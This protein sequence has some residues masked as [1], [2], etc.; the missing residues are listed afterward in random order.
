MNSTHHGGYGPSIQQVRRKSSACWGEV[1]FCL[2]TRLHWIAKYRTS[3]ERVDRYRQPLTTRHSHQDVLDDRE[4]EL[5]VEACGDLSAPRGF[6][7]RFICLLGG[8]PGPRAG[9]SAQFHT[10][11]LDWNRKVLRIPQHEP[12]NRGYCKRQARQEVAHNDRLIEADAVSSRWHPK[13]VASA[14]SIPFDLSIAR[15]YIRISGTATADALRRAHHREQNDHP[16]VRPASA[17]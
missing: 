5:Q 4:F 15:K 12:C 16:S 11:R 3:N 9:E 13:T 1:A 7:A 14:R 6:E 2:T 17:A 10:S 8:R